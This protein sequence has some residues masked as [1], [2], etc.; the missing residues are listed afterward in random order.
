MRKAVFLTLAVLFGPAAYLFAQP[1]PQD[2]IILESKTVYP[3]AHPGSATD[4]AAYVYLK[5]Y[6]TNK[7]SLSAIHVAL[8]ERSFSGGAYM[9][10]AHPRTFN[11][12]VSRLT[13]TLN[14]SVFTAMSKYNSTSPDSVLIAG[15]FDPLNDATVEPPNLTRKPFWEIKFDTVFNHP[16]TIELGTGVVVNPSGFTNT[17]PDDLPVNFVKSVITVFTNLPGPP[18]PRD[19][20][21]LETKKVA[22]IIGAAGGVRVKVYITNKDSLWGMALALEEKSTS[23]GAY[24]LFSHPRTYSGVVARLTNTLTNGVVNFDGYNSS[25]PDRCAISGFGDP[26]NPAAIEP[27]NSARKAVWEFKFDTVFNSAGTVEFDTAE[28]VLATGFSTA[29]GLALNVNSLKSVVTVV[30]N[31]LKGDLNLDGEVRPSDVVWELQCVFLGEIPPA[32]RAR[33]DLN[34]DGQATAADVAVF[35]TY[36]FL[37]LVWPC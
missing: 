22:S 13:N 30:T 16:G 4:T 29:G 12:V 18:D 35:L 8:I 7:D 9:T 2:S 27:P 15:L 11:G 25:S 19:S 20:I 33:C 24:M 26:L 21:I 1:H 37:T 28:Y 32:G 5:V 31:P 36:K 14:G 17:V 6:I 10:L 34:C 23:G 3:G